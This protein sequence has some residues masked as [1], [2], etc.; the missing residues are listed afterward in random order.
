MAK[1]MRSK[2]E[3]DISKAEDSLNRLGKGFD[4]VG[5]RAQRSAGESKKDWYGVANLFSDVLPR[6]MSRTI[7]KMQSST[8]SVGRLSKGFKGLKGAIASTGIGLLIVALG[9][10]VEHWDKITEALSGA[11]EAQKANNKANEA[12]TQT[13]NSMIASV[14]GSTGAIMRSTTSLEE[15]L[16][17]QEEL[18]R[19]VSLANE[20]DVSTAEGQRQIY[21]ATKRTIQIEGLRASQKA[22]ENALSEILEKKRVAQN[23]LDSRTSMRRARDRRIVADADREILDLTK[24]ISNTTERLLPLLVDEATEVERLTGEKKKLLEVDRELDRL[25]KEAEA[26]A[27]WAQK[28][29]GDLEDYFVLRGLEGV[30][31]EKK[32]LER[33]FTALRKEAEDR[34]VNEKELSITLQLLKAQEEDELYAIGQAARD[35]EQEAEDAQL[36]KDT[37][38]AD[39]IWLKSLDKF[40]KEEEMAARRM[41]KR[42]EGVEEGT[43]FELQIRKAYDVEMSEIDAKRTEEELNDIDKV[44]AAKIQAMRAVSSV[45]GQMESLAKKGSAEAKAFAVT[46]VLLNQAVAISQAVTAAGKAGMGTGLAAPI[47][48]PLF[49]IQMVGAVLA[50]FIGIKNILSEAGASAGGGY[51]EGG[52]GGGGSPSFSTAANIPNTPQ[53]QGFNNPWEGMSVQT[54]VVQSQLAAEQRQADRMAGLTTL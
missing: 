13:M 51:S 34:I 27:K 10:M 43:E 52:G 6:G 20:Y 25:K 38:T 45:L 4:D 17:A 31:R 44:A 3:V 26:D 49:I 39:E 11:T 5:R 1:E 32:V 19:T 8:R 22:K 30:D 46:Q 33:K 16:A 21:A 7:R 36:D 14:E 15:R 42:L 29:Y 47:T 40:D 48:T 2:V 24:S 35:K 37:Q 50:S 23:A 28:L 54:Y 9:A 53:D 18:S 12:S 41:L